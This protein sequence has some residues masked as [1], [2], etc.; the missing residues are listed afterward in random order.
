VPISLLTSAKTLPSTTS[1]SEFP[2]GTYEQGSNFLMKLP[3][4]GRRQHQ[5][6]SF[7]QLDKN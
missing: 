4:E 2:D 6:N 3:D 1:K 5:E 7:S